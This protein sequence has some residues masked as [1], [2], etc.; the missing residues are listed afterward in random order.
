MRI[1]DTHAAIHACEPADHQAAGIDFDSFHV[2]R[3]GNVSVLILFGALTGHS[4]LTVNVGASAGSKTTTVPFRH[5]LATGVFKAA[6]GD[7][8]GVETV[9]AAGGSLTLTDATY[10]HK[11]LIINIDSA[12]VPDATP[13]VTINIDG[14]AT[15]LLVAAFAL[16]AKPR[17]TPALTAIA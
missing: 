2:G 8:F 17:Q 16:G 11:V 14:T 3:M 6:S 4:V 12:A 1:I 9:V 5:Q 13:W 10:A 7:L 15:E